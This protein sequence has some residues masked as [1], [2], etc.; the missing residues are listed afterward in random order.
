MGLLLGLENEERTELVVPGL[1]R[2]RSYSLYGVLLLEF[3]GQMSS[4]VCPIPIRGPRN[5]IPSRLFSHRPT[6][7]EPGG[8]GDQVGTHLRIHRG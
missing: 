6:L 5:V 8:K 1:R 7:A 3:D 4:L 2:N